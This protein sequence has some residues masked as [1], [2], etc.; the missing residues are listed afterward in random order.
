MSNG[1][2]VNVREFEKLPQKQQVTAVFHNLVQQGV[3]QKEN[4]KK[5]IE[6]LEVHSKKFQDHEK[7]DDKRFWKLAS[8]LTL[9]AVITGAT[10]IWGAWF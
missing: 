8:G 5:I 7:K 4:Q 10:K 1:V 9:V 6:L 3:E 2:T